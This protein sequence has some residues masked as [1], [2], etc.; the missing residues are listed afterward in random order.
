MMVADVES[1]SGFSS[2][3]PRL[4]FQGQ[5]ATDPGY[6]SYAVLPGDQQFLMLKSAQSRIGELRVVLNWFE[7]LK[8]VG[9]K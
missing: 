1:R 5:Y 2:G 3:K 8:R 6:V 9:G 7:E 4:L